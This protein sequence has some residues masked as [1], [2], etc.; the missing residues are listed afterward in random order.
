[1][2]HDKLRYQVSADHVSP[3][4]RFVR[5]EAVAKRSPGR[6]GYWFATSDGLGCSKDYSSPDAAVRS[7]FQANACTN[8]RLYDA[9]QTSVEGRFSDCKR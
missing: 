9:G 3:R 6:E 1:M 2:A 5:H 7:L 8:I 4:Y